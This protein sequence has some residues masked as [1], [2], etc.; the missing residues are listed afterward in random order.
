M[1]RGARRLPV[2]KP[3]DVDRPGVGKAG[4]GAQ[5]AGRKTCYDWVPGREGSLL[6]PEGS[7]SLQ[8]QVAVGVMRHDVL[9]ILL[10]GGRLYGRA[11]VDARVRYGDHS[12]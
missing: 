12:K 3:E 5:E 11:L 7:K 10:E 9:G 2:H 1:G 8:Q 4:G 6:A